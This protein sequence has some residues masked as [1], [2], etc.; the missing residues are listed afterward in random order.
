MTRYPR[1]AR[2][3]ILAAL[4]GFAIFVGYAYTPMSNVPARL[5]LGLDLLTGIVPLW[6]FGALWII[7][8][9][10]GLAAIAL[11]RNGLAWF[12]FQFGMNLTW[13]GTYAAAWVA[14]DPRAWVTVGIFS[15]PAIVVAAATRVEPPL[16]SAPRWW[17]KWKH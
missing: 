7:S 11:R 8:G 12:A 3:V 5:P 16:W 9:A 15:L 17:R 14:G 1:E 4:S 6:V 10:G 13:M 2:E